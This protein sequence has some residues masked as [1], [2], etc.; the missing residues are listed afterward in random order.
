MLGQ[1]IRITDSWTDQANCKGKTELFFEGR[2]EKPS[3]RRRREAKAAKVCADCPVIYQCRMFARENGE[4]GFWGGESDD[5]RWQLGY[6][7]N[8]TIARRHKARVSR[9][10]L[11]ESK[12]RVDDSIS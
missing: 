3:E 1:R 12:N 10:A 4:Y 7:K 8:P 11:K 6:L 2:H 9:A 5:E